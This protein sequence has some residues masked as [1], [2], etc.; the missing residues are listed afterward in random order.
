MTKS[1]SPCILYVGT[2]PPRECGIAT[3]TKDLTD[4]IDKEF[5]PGVKGR[6][7]AIND[8][9]TSIYNYPRKVMLQIN[10]TNI[11]DYLNIAN[12]INRLNQIKLV[13][14]QH[15]YGI[16][17]GDWGNYLLPFLELLKKPVVITM[18]TVLPRPQE[19]L[20]KLTQSIINRSAAV[21]VMTKSATRLLE[22][23]YG[24]SKSKIFIIPHG[25][26]NIT[27]PSKFKAKKKLNLSDKFV[28]STFGMLN[29]D[30]GIEYA[31][32]AL[33]EIIKEFPNVLYLIL[34]AT[35]PVVLKQ[36]GE[37]YRNK[38]KKLVMKL[39]LKDY[40]KFYN[41]YLSVP[42]LIEYL[43]ATDIYVSPTLNPR[44]S[45]S[46]T[47]SYALSCACPIIATANQ[48]AKDVIEPGHRGYLTGFRDA[49]AIEKAL[50]DLLRDKA[51]RKEMGKN[52]YFYS[53]HMTFQNVAL[54][55]FNLFNDLA[56][57]VPREKGK[58]PIINLD[59]I[60]TLTDKFGIIQFATHTK[61]DPHS[62]YCLDDNARA[63]LGCAMY[64]KLNPSK[65]VLNLINIYFN[66]IKFSQKPNGEFHPFVNYNK[67]FN[68]D[69]GESEDSFGRAIW[70]LGYA[71]SREHLPDDLRKKAAK[72]FNKAVKSAP[73]LKSSRAIAFV[74][75]G[76]CL[77]EEKESD[78][79]RLLLIKK[80]ADKLAKGYLKQIGEDPKK[81]WH[82]FENCLT[83][84]N[85]KLPEALLRAYQITKNKEYLPV[86][87]N[88][89]KFLMKISF[90]KGYFSPIG[91][92][93]WFFR[94]G[95]RSYFDQQPEDTASAVEALLAA[96]QI[97]KKKDYLNKAKLSFE[98]FLGKNH[99]NQMIYDEATGG[100]YDGLG[101]Y[102]INFNQ[103]AESTISYFLA[104]LVMDD[105]K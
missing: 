28:L 38:L 31:I 18:H 84:S 92:D 76:L 62:G 68:S 19:K 96:Y 14:I 17:G 69:E 24:I 86:A 36:E 47:V 95:K 61:P 21:V 41:K 29:R 4:A 80:L 102:S 100:C 16:F 7:L 13:N 87:E 89:L 91:Q 32:E 34:G 10:E 94:N 6:I 33:P 51:A 99:L 82:W 65:S 30:K 49:K 43:K 35:H 98:W 27:F 93:G 70:T 9:G 26:H 85:Y 59:H 46:G 97:T 90:E 39:G 63:L 25:V 15:E 71:A 20:K 48:Y 104:R 56:K 1:K 58:P 67:T 2:Y 77:A 11:E 3:F 8:N 101:K 73:N 54:S 44:Q 45:V 55:Y 79:G 50:F 23:S 53:R 75:L 72:I 103:G 88:S 78:A 105:V 37:R 66:F 42:E 60:K 57:I 74:L 22:N 52:A 12:E 81:N 64:Y 83:Y 5:S 40:V